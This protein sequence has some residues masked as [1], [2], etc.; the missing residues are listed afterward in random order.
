MD[1]RRFVGSAALV[2]LG[3][4]AGSLLAGC[5][6]EESAAPDF[7]GKQ[8]TSRAMQLLTGVSRALFPHR[9]APDEPYRGVATALDDRASADAGVAGL[10][11]TAV[12]ELDAAAGGDWLAATPELKVASLEALQDSAWFGLILNTAID[13]VYRHP[14][15]WA[16]VGYEGSSMEFGGY[17]NRG[18]DDIDWLPQT[19]DGAG[20]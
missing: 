2:A 20:R 11:A 3:P 16:L 4:L 7:S 8:L 14:D 6:D 10:L 15:I 13:V 18:F 9:D 5:S 17:L 19:A 12:A 1:R